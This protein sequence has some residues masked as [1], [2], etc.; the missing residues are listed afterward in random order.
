MAGTGSEFLF[1]GDVESG[2]RRKGEEGYDVEHVRLADGYN[3]AI[4]EEAARSWDAGR[5]AGIF[6]SDCVFAGSRQLMW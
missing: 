3:R 2:W 6:V 5:L 1:F 4:W